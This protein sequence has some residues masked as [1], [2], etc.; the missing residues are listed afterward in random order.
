MHL[1]MCASVFGYV[2]TAVRTSNTWHE[3]RGQ[4]NNKK[5]PARTDPDPAPSAD[6]IR[7]HWRRRCRKPIHFCQHQAVEPSHLQC[8]AVRLATL[9]VCVSICFD[10]DCQVSPTDTC[11]HCMT[12]LGSFFWHPLA[13][14]VCA[15]QRVQLQ[16][17]TVLNLY[18]TRFLA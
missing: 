18:N 16:K 8:L 9:S 3:P 13:I 14:D 6:P 11:L 5:L 7:W 4:N 1:C 17:Q 2:L 10:A 12:P 15:S